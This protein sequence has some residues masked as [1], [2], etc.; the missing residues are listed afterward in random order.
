MRFDFTKGDWKVKKYRRKLLLALFTAAV[1]ASSLF[2][3]V[4]GAEYDDAMKT[5]SLD[6]SVEV[7]GDGSMNVKETF[8]VDFLDERHGIFRNIPLSG[9]ITYKDGDKPV[10]YEA[11]L[12]ISKIKVENHNFSVSKKR[13]NLVIKIGDKSKTVMG[14]Q[15]YVISYHLQPL[16]KGN[17][18]PEVFYMNLM[19]TQWPNDIE[20]GTFKVQMPKA[21]PS[22]NVRIYIGTPGHWQSGNVQFNEGN[23][24]FEWKIDNLKMGDAVTMFSKLPAGY[25]SQPEEAF[26]RSPVFYIGLSLSVTILLIILWFLFG[27]D[28]KI[29]PTV[30]IKP[31]DWMNPINVAGI[32]KK[33]ITPSNFMGLLVYMANKGYITMD[34]S[35]GK[36]SLVLTKNAPVP[37]TESCAIREIVRKIF[38]GTKQVDL[39]DENFTGWS[40]MYLSLRNATLEGSNYD[41]SL[42]TNLADKCRICMYVIIG[43]YLAATAGAIDM[44][45]GTFRTISFFILPCMVV[46]VAMC[47][48]IKDK[49]INMGKVKRA[50][51]LLVL[52]LSVAGIG[53][54]ISHA[55]QWMMTAY[56]IGYLI[57]ILFAI[58]VLTALFGDKLSNEGVEKY[59]QVLGF[60]NYIETAQ[61]D[62]LRVL[63]EENPSIFYDILPYACIFGLHKV[64]MDKFADIDVGSP[65]WGSGTWDA[66][67]MST[68]YNTGYSA[69]YDKM[70]V[71]GQFGSS[72]G[73]GSFDFGGGGFAG[74]GFGGGGGGSW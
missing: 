69:A 2:T 37:K 36:E 70:D 48:L 15:H 32:Y 23:T 39:Y 1:M 29:I 10:T 72:D 73:G 61:K 51:T 71:S 60:K 38:L 33:S 12:I 44:G 55:L 25:F 18:A 58:M 49:F 43:F 9:T 45:T 4:F 22:Y 67:R 31:R 57:A 6:V 63:A 30:E 7:A 68:L 54:C 35:G 28:K 46:M 27:R 16:L 3:Y 50:V 14:K 20:H 65:S 34:D 41:H 40:N 52:L 74:G 56:N 5:K 66:V 64:W 47:I 8:D 11:R 42:K 17:K 24:L 26:Y 21:T 19:G 13:D 62:R 53:K 59:G